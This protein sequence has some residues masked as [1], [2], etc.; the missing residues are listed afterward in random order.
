MVDDYTHK[1]L[2]SVGQVT[3]DNLIEEEKVSKKEIV[4]SP[5][6]L[7]L[8]TQLIE[9]MTNG[10]QRY[11]G[12]KS[13]GD[14]KDNEKMRGPRTFLP[15]RYDNPNNLKTM[16]VKG[17]TMGWCSIDYHDRSMWCGRSTCLNRSEYA[18]KMKKQRETNSGD[19][20]NPGKQS[21]GKFSEDF[22]IALAAMIPSAD[23]ESLESQFMTS[24]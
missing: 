16:V 14:D 20:A 22:K 4:K 1:N 12:S 11:S 7:V 2:L 5:H 8:S 9:T 10:K 13:K 19:K 17:T 15:W 23:F 24:N 3:Y 18:A 6:F 21:G